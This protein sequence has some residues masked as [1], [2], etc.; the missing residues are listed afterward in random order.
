MLLTKENDF[1]SFFKHEIEIQT[2][3]LHNLEWLQQIFIRACLFLSQIPRIMLGVSNYSDNSTK[4]NGA[5]AG[6]K[7]KPSPTRQRAVTLRVT[8][9]SRFKVKFRK[10]QDRL[11]CR[12]RRGYWAQVFISLTLL[13]NIKSFIVLPIEVSNSDRN[14]VA[15]LRKNRN[16]LK[17]DRLEKVWLKR[18]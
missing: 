1:P 11:N 12:L 3:Y 8:P 17:V 2:R 6:P 7:F 10:P 9:K 18:G 15:W 16:I 13:Q 4:K 14:R 5:F